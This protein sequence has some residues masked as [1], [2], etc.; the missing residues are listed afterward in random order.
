MTG[1]DTTRLVWDPE[2][3]SWTDPTQQ[4]TA[5]SAA[6]VRP[7]SHLRTAV[8]GGLVGALLASALTLG[9]VRAVPDRSPVAVETRLPPDAAAG[10][11]TGTI[12]DIAARARPTVVNVNV[13]VRQQGFFG[14]TTAQGTGSGV[15]LRSDGFIITNAH[16]AEGASRVE[17]TLSSAEKLPAR[18]VGID[19]DTDVA[20][21]KV[22]KTGLETALIGSAKDLVVGELAVAIGSPLGL[23]QTVTAGIISALGRAVERPGQPP[24]VDMIQ[25]DAAVT[26]GNSGGA[27]L[28]GRGALIGINSAIA[29]SPTVG[30]EGIAFAIP[31]DIAK[32]VAD[33][34][35]ATGKATHPW[36]GVSGAQLDPGSSSRFGVRQGAL[37]V[38]VVP[39]GP[40]DKAGIKPD[41]VVVSLG[42]EKIEGMD[43]LIIAIRERRVGDTVKVEYVRLGQTLTATVTLGDRPGR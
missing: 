2:S 29:A 25:T 26:Q 1:D 37:I 30:A 5:R 42:G 24:L 27:L 17:V 19:E 34:L 11:E 13:V 23:E 9:I 22:E 3:R 7:A 16:V 32:A 12:V 39:G 8:V 21:L 41:D 28:D 35:I 43:D 36:I 6:P 15:I 14:T 38:E 33:E 20:V 31:I 40:A 18:V 10:R 4:P